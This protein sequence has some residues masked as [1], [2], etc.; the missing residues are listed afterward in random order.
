MTS[1]DFI[2]GN[3]HIQIGIEGAKEFVQRFLALDRFSAPLFLITG[4]QSFESS[5]AASFFEPII[6][7]KQVVRFSDFTA[8]PKIEDLS[9]ALNAFKKSKAHLI[10]AVGGGSALDIAKLVNYFAAKGI[11][12]A[13]YTEGKR[14]DGD[15]F[16]PMLAVPTT[17]GT[18]SETTHFATL[19]V[20]FEK[21]S[22]ADKRMIPSHIFLNQAFTSTMS[23]YLTAC[24]GFDALSQAIESYWAVGS[25]EESKQYCE[26]AIKLCLRHLEGAVFDPSAEHRTGML[27]ASYLAGRAINI[28][29]T[30]AA[31]ALSYPMTAHYGLP[32]GH[33]V[34]MTLPALFEANADATEKELNDL[35][36]FKYL[37]TVMTA[38]C[39]LL[40][41]NTPNKAAKKLETL[42]ER[43][44]L[45][46][47]WFI[48]HGFNPEDVRNVILQEINE[49]RLANNP[50]KLD[51]KIIIQIVT[52]IM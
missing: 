4:R 9:L 41:E 44:M 10:I 27:K 17:A 35:R 8:N 19:Y 24:T 1:D 6:A 23:A 5:G 49:E 51:K 16:C 7:G 34:S 32:H 50:R 11:D 15:A 37:S 46:R 2:K 31:H 12:P 28:S 52:D 42:K 33:A 25:T 29:K 14:G 26:K 45:S 3:E 48:E 30:T 38:L 39:I 43:I 36:G 47:T 18:G 13:S 21:I 40:G 22:I 20:G